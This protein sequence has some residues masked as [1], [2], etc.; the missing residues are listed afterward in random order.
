MLVCR[1]SSQAIFD[2]SLVKGGFVRSAAKF[3]SLSMRVHLS[4]QFKHEAA[5]ISYV[6]GTLPHSTLI[7]RPR[8]LDDRYSINSK[9]KS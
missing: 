1:D 8:R 7:C 9:S 2:L 5:L 6:Y 3:F 4:R